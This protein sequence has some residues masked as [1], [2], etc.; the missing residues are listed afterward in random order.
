MAA[1]KGRKLTNEETKEVLSLERKDITKTLLENYFA[2]FKGQDHARFN[3]YDEMLVPAGAIYPGVPKTNTESTIGRYIFNMYVLPE[4]YL[5]KFGYFNDVLKKKQL[6]NIE[7]KIGVMVL[8][9]EISSKELAGYIDRGE[10]LGM[11]M[12]YY[13]VPSLS[14]EFNV[15][16]PEVIKLRDELFDKYHDGVAR[17]DNNTAEKIEKE[18]VDLARKTIK[19]KGDESYDFYDSGVGS[20]E[21]NYKKTSI[22]AGAIENP[23]T[24]KLD[25]LKSNYIDGIDKKEFPKFANLTLIG[26]YSRGVETQGSGYETKKVN[27]SMQI[28]TLDK[29]G[30]DCGT[31]NYENIVI[32][33]DLKKRFYYRYILDPGAPGHDDHGLVML[34]EDNIDR[35]AGKLVKMRSPLFCKGKKICS[36]CA[37]ELYYKMGVENAGLLASTIT[38][39]LLNLSRKK[40]HDATIRFSH[41]DP[42]KYIK[43]A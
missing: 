16:I 7:D 36:K 37:G 10:W 35:Y 17:G 12:A 39:H 33:E 28:V 5:R 32:P 9:D 21:N 8:N 43:K 14:Y 1:P 34:N 30:S 29:D 23:Y 31:T 41:I 24:K 42:T 13:I 19:E 3:T 26:G 38:G 40:F 25:I 15:P 22:M 18:V 20:F 2:C 27:S 11:G 6:G 4:A